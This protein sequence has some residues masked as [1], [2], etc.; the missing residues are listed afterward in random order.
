M[1]AAAY[2]FPAAAALGALGSGRVGPGRGLAPWALGLAAFAAAIGREPLLAPLALF[3]VATTAAVATAARGRGDPRSAALLALSDLA[4]AAALTLHHESTTLWSLPVAGGWAWPA[5][6]LAAGAAGLRL[7][8][9]G[10][11]AG[12]WGALG[13]WQGA[14]VAWWVGGAGWPVLV[15]GAAWL[16]VLGAV[17]ARRGRPD[18]GPAVAGSLVAL[19][20]AAGAGPLPLAAL[21]LA[22]AA[23]AAGERVVAGSA[24]GLLP[25][26][27]AALAVQRG[28]GEVPLGA[29]LAVAAGLPVAWAALLHHLPPAAP[30]PGWRTAVVAAAAAGGSLATL[31]QVPGQAPWIAYGALAALLGADLLSV[32]APVREVAAAPPTP[33]EEPSRP[34]SVVAVAAL[35]L[36]GGL[37]VRLLVL[38]LGTSFL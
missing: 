22:G 32:R 14:L 20:A 30:A 1:T 25:V 23:F 29:L 16:L 21:G 15:A 19:V 3:A 31:A 17:R 36:A 13:W 26:S 37:Q 34:A 10:R 11:D 24:L 28:P 2:L 12:G 6:L 35:A 38:G 5:G 8:A 7:G 33:P 4:L 27:A 9:S 18:V